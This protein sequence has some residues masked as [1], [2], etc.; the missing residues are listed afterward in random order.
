VTEKSV[1]CVF[2]SSRGDSAGRLIEEA[3]CK[4]L[5]RG[6]LVVSGKHAKYFVYEGEATCKDLLE[7]MAEV[8]KRVKS[9]F[10]VELKPEV[11]I[12]AM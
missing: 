12:W 7:L 4:L 8:Q 9:E 5:R 11:R 3:G 2:T 1:G 6:G 10:G